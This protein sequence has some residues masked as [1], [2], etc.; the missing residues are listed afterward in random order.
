MINL[1]K[2]IRFGHPVTR[3]EDNRFLTGKGKYVSDIYIPRMA[4]A[5]MLRAQVPAGFIKSIDISIAQSSDGVIDILTSKD[6]KSEN[7][8]SLIPLISRSRIDGS[9][10]FVPPYPLLVDHNI[11]HLGDIIALVIAESSAQAEIA[12]ELIKTDIEILPAVVSVAE[13]AAPN[14]EVVWKEEPSNICFVEKLGNSSLT[15]TIFSNAP[16]V[17]EEEYVI[18]RII[19]HPMETRSAIGLYNQ[20]DGQYTLHAGLQ[21]PHIVRDT[22]AKNVLRID[23]D[24]LRVISPDIGGGF[25]LKASAQRELALVLWG[26]KVTGRPV[27]WVSE[28]TESFIGDHHAR[29]NVSKVS[30][31]L[32]DSAKFLGLKVRT[33]AN[34]GAYI[35]TFGLHIPVGNLGGLS[36]P[37]AIGSF[38]IKVQGIFTNTQPTAPYRGAGRPEATYC[39]E[40]IVD[41]AAKRLGISPIEIR[42]RNMILPDEM[43]YDTGLVFSYDIGEFE[44]TMDKA[45]YLADFDGRRL[46]AKNARSKGLVHGTGLAYAIE[47]AGGPQ[48]S[49]L[50]EFAEVTFNAVG[51]AI[52]KI[53]THN[54]GQ[55]HETAF[56]QILTH[57]LGVDPERT[58]ILFGDTA[59]VPEGTGTFGSRSI[60]IG[61]AALEHVSKIIIKDGYPL[62]ARFLEASEQDIRFIDGSYFI[63]GTDH[64]LSLHD[65]AKRVATL[66]NESTDGTQQLNAN[67]VMSPEN[68]TFPNACH[69]CEVEIDPETGKIWLTRYTVMDD[70]GTVLNPLLL[71]GQIHG[72]VAQGVGQALHEIITMDESSGQLLSGSLMDYC[73]PRADDLP[74]ISVEAH[75]VPSS[76]TP[77][78]FKGA[79]EAGTVGSIPA[80]MNAV[81]DALASLGIKNFDMPATPERIWR[82]INST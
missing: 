63:T 23:P 62:A 57:A 24:N 67:I 55:G 15:E 68:S 43:P 14:P 2:S 36:G 30:L 54:H 7:F 61:G 71:E 26:A 59:I 60:A 69:I 66:P 21:T 79:G 10:N 29:D 25:G 46:R 39:I 22:I 73:I 20:E 49:P 74:M 76:N 35:D 31:A 27:K 45:L 32:D 64:K 19:A 44:K 47:I 41:K 56:R 34:L 11:M 52:V 5:K 4:Y 77:F 75:E 16:H 82:A 42:R 9:P 12:V 17:V 33:I 53:G 37:Y 13:A 6:L 72:G 65:I 18:S 80:V 38:D 51:D 70:V 48:D 58:Q 81:S 78:G 1:Q 50:P 40:R 3:F 8:G 28:R